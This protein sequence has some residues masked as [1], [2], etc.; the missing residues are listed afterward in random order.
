VKVL[1][2][3][4]LKADPKGLARE[5][6]A[7]LGV[8]ATFAYAAADEKA[9]AASAARS[10]ALGTAAK[11]LSVAARSMGMANLVGRVK[12]CSLVH[13]LLYRP[14]TAADR[15]AETGLTESQRDRLR[16]Y[17]RDDV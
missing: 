4:D 16:A 11:R 12:D 17:Y 1:L 6:Y 5:V 9:L 14:M 13:R 10:G 15:A 7:Y 8:D 3:D 2:F